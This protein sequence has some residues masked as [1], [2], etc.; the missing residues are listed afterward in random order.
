MR[1]TS[2]SSWASE[3]TASSRPRPSSP[4]ASSRLTLTIGSSPPRPDA[5]GSRSPSTG[6]P[7][8]SAS[9]ASSAWAGRLAASMAS[10]YVRMP[11]GHSVQALVDGHER[12]LDVLVGEAHDHRLPA[13]REPILVEETLTGCEETAAASSPNPI[14]SSSDGPHLAVRAAR[15]PDQGLVD[16]VEE[17]RCLDDRHVDGNARCLDHPRGGERDA[18]DALRV[19]D[20]ALRQPPGGQDP[21]RLLAIGNCHV[22]MLPGSPPGVPASRVAAG[23]RRRGPAMLLERAGCGGPARPRALTDQVAPSDRTSSVPSRSVRSTETPASARTRMVFGLG[24]PYSL[25]APTLTSPRAGWSAATK[26][27]V[28]PEFEP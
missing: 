9:S 22:A 3:A 25:S 7:A 10:R 12:L 16:V 19:P 20:D 21:C 27:G 23:P 28:V 26:S 14:V 13:P 15:L 1:W 24:C 8:T 4:C 2:P 18:G 6:I 17:G 5:A 11:P